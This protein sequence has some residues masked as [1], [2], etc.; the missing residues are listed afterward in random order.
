LA[1]AVFAKLPDNS[2]AIFKVKIIESVLN[3]SNA[4]D[5]ESKSILVIPL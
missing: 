4:D 5:K 2:L 1:I 3:G